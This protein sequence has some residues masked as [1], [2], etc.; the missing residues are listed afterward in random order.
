M[1]YISL[2]FLHDY[3]DIR[4]SATYDSCVQCM[5]ILKQSFYLR[6]RQRSVNLMFIQCLVIC[7]ACKMNILQHF[8]NNDLKQNIRI[9][10]APIK[11]ILFICSKLSYHTKMKKK[12]L[13]FINILQNIYQHIL[14]MLIMKFVTTLAIICYA[15]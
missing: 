3:P 5:F 7:F 14:C 12:P 11:R 15:S 4:K 8:D 6:N 1:N 2:C 9:L 10:I 13:V